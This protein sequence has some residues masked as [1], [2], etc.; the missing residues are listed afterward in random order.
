MFPFKAASFH[1]YCALL[2]TQT[3]R[4]VLV[5]NME[6]RLTGW[7]RVRWGLITRVKLRSTSH[8][9]VSRHVFMS[10]AFMIGSVVKYWMFFTSVALLTCWKLAMNTSYV[11]ENFDFWKRNLKLRFWLVLSDDPTAITLEPGLPGGFLQLLKSCRLKYWHCKGFNHNRETFL[12][13]STACRLKHLSE[14]VVYLAY[15]ITCYFFFKLNSVYTHK[16][17]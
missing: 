9:R 1:F 15:P 2:S 7:T 11:A 13:E 4:V 16:P 17:K 3:T 6:Y 8:R 5:V 10:Q 12:K 14:L